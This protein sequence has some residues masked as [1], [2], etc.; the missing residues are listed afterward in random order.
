MEKSDVVVIGGSAA[1]LTAALTSRRHYPE[2]SVL[3][4]R[5][6][7]K[8]LVPCGIPYIFGTLGDWS[9]NLMPDAPLSKNKID[10][11]IDEVTS[12]NP[13]GKTVTTAGG[14]EV[15]YQRLVLATGSDPVVP[16]IP[17]R[18][19]ENIF[20]IAKDVA[21][22]EGMLVA[23][24]KASNVLIVGCGFIGV[25]IAEE[26]KKTRDVRDA[27]CLDRFTC[28][29]SVGKRGRDSYCQLMEIFH[30]LGPIVLSHGG[31]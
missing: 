16:P 7:E 9:K 5:K 24:D 8:V 18:D 30:S 15:S 10:L 23:L 22:L 27:S 31:T 19:L 6:E 12:I 28:C 3:L 14:K 4:I 26:C 11:L 21:Y 17:G 25:E 2:K 13:E 1:G 29:L 20:A